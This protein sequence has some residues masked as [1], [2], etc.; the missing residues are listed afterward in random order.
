M[1]RNKFILVM[2]IGSLCFFGMIN[3]DAANV[4]NKNI[5]A[6]YEYNESGDN[7][8]ITG[9]ESTCK[10][11]APT[12]YQE[13]TIVKYAVNDSE[14]KYFYVLN[15]DGE[16]LT[17]QQRENTIY[18]TAWYSGSNDN[19]K[20]PLTI[21]PILESATSG[22]I[23]V[24]DQTYTMG[25][26]AFKTNAYTGCSAYNSCT[27]N[28]YTLDQRT[29]KARMITVQE[30][31]AIGCT[32]T[33][34][35]CPKWMNNYLSD[36]TSYGGTV[37]D[38]TGGNIY[39]YWTMSAYSSADAGCACSVD[40]SGCLSNDDTSSPYYATR[41]V[42]EIDKYS[43][44]DVIIND[45]ETPTKENNNNNKN[46]TQTVDVEDTF[47]TAYIGYCIGTI[48]LIFGIMVIYQSYRKE[49]QEIK[50]KKY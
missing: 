25:T 17:M 18:N 28:T 6:V 43:T 49:K 46:G 20:G 34:K 30:A 37:N 44:S 41:A 27:A 42:V 31:A 7:L 4:I 33:N 39:G 48:I 38:T 23:N 47:K 50:I 29:G 35:S 14:E 15:D 3:V 45:N 32:G 1:K 11:I 5:K 12:T 40:H 36:S 21:L 26:T 24:N 10:S 9:E 16:T 13:G 8:C 19:S 2:I 22:W